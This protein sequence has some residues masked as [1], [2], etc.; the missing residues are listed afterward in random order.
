MKSHRRKFIQGLAA[1][2]LAPAML[3]GTGALAAKDRRPNI[4]VLLADDMGYADLGCFGS[5]HIRTPNLD[6]LATQGV[7][8]TNCSSN[9]PVCSTTRLSLFW[10]FQGH[11]QRA[12]RI[13]NWKYYRLEDNEFLFDLS[14]DTMERA[15]RAEHEPEV[16][17]RLKSAWLKWNEGMITDDSIAG[18]CQ[19]PKN[20]AGMLQTSEGTNCKVYGPRPGAPPR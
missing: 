1:S 19:S 20:L 4:L 13:R 14:V 11:R 16:M 2:G 5:R 8:L 15:S 10:R 6:R 9:S 7:R 17:D 18:F 12:A 3:G